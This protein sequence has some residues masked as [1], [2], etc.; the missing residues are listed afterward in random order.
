MRA[1]GRR[2]KPH[3]HIDPIY[4]VP[5]TLESPCLKTVSSGGPKSSSEGKIVLTK[6]LL[7]YGEVAEVGHFACKDSKR[8]YIW[9]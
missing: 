5:E 3:A 8:W 6:I 4:Y 2:R 1:E 9:Q 7:L